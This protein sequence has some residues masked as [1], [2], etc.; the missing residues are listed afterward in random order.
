M[1]RYNDIKTVKI[2]IC[3]AGLIMVAGISG[4]KK[5]IDIGAPTTLINTANVYTSDGT[6]EAAVS[7][8][9][10]SLASSGH[11]YNGTGSISILQGLAADEFTFYAAPAS[12]P[13]N[14][15]YANSLTTLN[16]NNYYWPEIYSE[17]FICN[18]VIQGLSSASAA[19]LTPAVQAQLMGE[20]KFIRAFIY[21]NAV[22]LYGD[23]PLILGTD[24]AV[25]S[26][27]SRAPAATV[28][29]QVI[30]DLIDAQSLL[31]DNSYVTLAGLTTTSR[32]L[33]NKQAVNALLSRVYLY[34]KDWKNAEAQASNIINAS[35]YVLE[36]VLTNVF[37]K[38]SREAIWQLQSIS[39]NYGNADVNVLLMVAA[40]TS[41]A[42]DYALSNSLLGAFEGGDNRFSN[43]VGKISS[44]AN[45][46]YY[47]AKYKQN[48]VASV[49]LITE[50]PIMFRLAEQYLIRAESRAQQ[51][52]NIGAQSDLNA[53][54]TRAGL[55]NT[56][57]T[58][59]SDLLNA[60]YNERRIEL[61]TEFGHRWFDL[62]RTG[63]LDAVMGVAAPLKGGTWSSYKALIPLPLTE[64]QADSHLTQNPGY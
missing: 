8:L 2:L 45:T 40:P 58:T 47:A 46:Y 24:P 19:S 14:L 7:G 31:P 25:N 39:V 35:S 50:Y 16:N 62:K 32:I 51:N 59:Q 55:G 11:M 41:V 6:A 10:S 60:I 56:T 54:R 33:P 15:F 52:N 34:T 28:I 44:G 1:K 29:Q 18:S 3:L 63:Q 23:V 64:I 53:I 4:C 37:L 20:V 57:A 12:S 13:P 9:L 36:P 22:N 43:W 26:I 17:I 30:K 38:A 42:N 5:A 48:S 27:A 21:F 61:F 49:S